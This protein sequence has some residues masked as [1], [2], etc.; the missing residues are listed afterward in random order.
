[1]IREKISKMQLPNSSIINKKWNFF[2]N[3]ITKI[4]RKY[5]P[6]KKIILTNSTIFNTTCSEIHKE[7]KQIAQQLKNIKKEKNISLSNN[8]KTKLTQLSLDISSTPKI[9]SSLKTLQQLTHKQ[10]SI[11]LNI[12]KKEK[13]KRQSKTELLSFQ[14]NPNF[15]LTIY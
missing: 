2:N 7:L 8:L 13:I 6:R 15:L 10:L 5:C 9:M 1:M 14:Q 4:K 3:K 12:Y 11:E